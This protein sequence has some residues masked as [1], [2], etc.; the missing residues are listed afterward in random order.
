MEVRFDPRAASKRDQ[1][2]DLH[3][4]CSNIRTEHADGFSAKTSRLPP[5]TLLASLQFLQSRR[6]GSITDPKLHAAP[7]PP[8]LRP[9]GPILGDLHSSPLVPTFPRDLSEGSTRMATSAIA[10]SSDNVAGT[11]SRS[12][13][14]SKL[15][16]DT[17]KHIERPIFLEGTRGLIRA[18]TTQRSRRQSTRMILTNRQR[19]SLAR[20]ESSPA[21]T[22][23][24]TLTPNL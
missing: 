24:S 17:G 2:V 5:V 1:T 19:P 3:S 20:N 23:R 15:A 12:K 13:R 4:S 18:R 22:H 10:A 7:N 9:P 14:G 8:L 6:R 16:E 21:P 11:K